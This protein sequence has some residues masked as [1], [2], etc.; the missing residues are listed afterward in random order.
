[1][2][3]STPWCR[4]PSCSQQQPSGLT[5]LTGHAHLW[6]FAHS[7]PVAAADWSPA[8]ADTRLWTDRHQ[9]HT[10]CITSVYGAERTKHMNSERLGVIGR[11]MREP[12][13]LGTTIYVTD[14][15]RVFSMK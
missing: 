12:S 10:S 5:K 7:V 1:M 11:S 6:R 13:P 15:K 2:H 3:M 4:E 9:R 14:V 8:V